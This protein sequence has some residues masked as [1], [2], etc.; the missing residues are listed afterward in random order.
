MAYI[1]TRPADE[2]A[3]E[4]GGRDASNGKENPQPVTGLEPYNAIDVAPLSSARNLR[5]SINPLQT[6]AGGQEPPSRLSRG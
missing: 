1:T 6:A 4:H 2:Q 5:S 3:A